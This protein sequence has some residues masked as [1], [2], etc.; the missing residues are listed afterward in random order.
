[1]SNYVQTTF[2]CPKDSLLSGN[3]AKLIKGCDV[4][5]E[6]AAISVAIATK[7]DS[8]NAANPTGTI[9][10][11]VVNGSAPSYMRSDA[12][13]PLSQAIVPTWTGAHT[14]Q[15]AS[16]TTAISV[17]SAGVSD[18]AVNIN[19]A[20]SGQ[21]AIAWFVSAA[22]KAFTMIAGATGQGVAGSAAGDFVVR[23]QGGAVRFS[24]NSGA[25]TQVFIPGN[26][27]SNALQVVDDAGTL[28]TVG[29][30]DMPPTGNG[31]SY[32]LV[33]ADRGKSLF[34]NSA[35]ANTVTIPANASVAFPVGT[36]VS[37]FNNPFAAGTTTVA[38]TSDTL[39]VP[40]LGTGSRTLPPGAMLTIQK[41]AATLWMGAGAGIT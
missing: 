22:V 6:L 40:G 4:D 20:A 12:A 26:T 11:T 38:I 17:N 10:L 35:S 27:N 15:P 29:W 37:I 28:Q 31:A 30:R 36:V 34:Q 41:V 33:M 9:G 32:T 18:V 5:P 25:A 7:L 39:S 16:G 3:P 2:F 19:G 21:A 13:P 1:M 8:S 23:T 24:N 14:F